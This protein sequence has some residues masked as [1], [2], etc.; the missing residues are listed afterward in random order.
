MH[1]TQ[2]MYFLKSN[3]FYLK[4][5]FLTSIFIKIVTVRYRIRND[6]AGCARR[7]F[8]VRARRDS[9]RFLSVKK[10]RFI[11]AYVYVFL[12]VVHA[13]RVSVS[14]SVCIVNYKLAVYKC[15]CVC[16]TLRTCYV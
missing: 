12:Q 1:R 3:N 11:Q 13:V 6:F 5:F 7:D 9:T 16:Y 4:H 15:A 10:E 8:Q 14:V 2:K